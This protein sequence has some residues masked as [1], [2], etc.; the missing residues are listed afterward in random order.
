MAVMTD[1]AAVSGA[2]ASTTKALKTGAQEAA[3]TQNGNVLDI[4]DIRCAAVEINLKDEIN[5]L[6]KP[7][8]GPRKLPTL[9]LYDERGLQLFEEARLV[10]CHH[11]LWL[12][13][14]PSS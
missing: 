3:S 8:T 7:K 11:R 12:C 14:H 9:L 5:T 2:P 10:P 13:F 6:F 4:I 1:T